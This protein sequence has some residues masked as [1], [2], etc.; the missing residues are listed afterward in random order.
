MSSAN[1]SQTG[2]RVVRLRKL[3]ALAS[4]LAMAIGQ[5]V[6][7][8]HMRQSLCWRSE[9]DAGAKRPARS[10]DLK[11]NSQ[12]GSKMSSDPPASGSSSAVPPVEARLATGV[13]GLDGL[14]GGGLLPGT[15]TVV[16]GA[17]GIGK[18]QL[19]LQFADAGLGQEGRRGVLFDMNARI[20]S[21]SHAEYAQRMFGWRLAAVNA[22]A[23]PELDG[24]YAPERDHG[25]YLHVFDKGGRR[26]TQREAGF[27]GWHDWHAELAAK[28]QVTIAFFYGN[29]TRG[30][31][32]AVIDGIEPAERPSESIQ[33]ELFE[34]VYHQIL[35]KESEWV[36]RDLLRQKYREL[37]DT[38]TAHRYEPAQVGCVL[39]YTSHEA[40]L[41]ALIERPFTDGD[42]LANANTL[43][44]MGKV[45]E[46][47]R[48]SRGLFVAK[49]RG[50]ACSDQ[51]VP[52]SIDDAGLKIQ[53]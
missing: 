24:F 10:I 9:S 32:R 5:R 22:A 27:D 53:H 16:V 36:A 28:L 12:P 17:S 34:Y 46:G 23:Q 6:A 39:L 18:T 25:S 1:A 41:D 7:N 13:P 19:G 26:V 35:R 47:N 52:Y 20:D 14:L 30:V 49:H 31:R 48:L 3:Q 29:F 51:I 21:Q 45:R 50:S 43:I 2:N 4:F 42:L 33:F 38:V 37:A 40:M 11:P 8:A 44:Y 15:L